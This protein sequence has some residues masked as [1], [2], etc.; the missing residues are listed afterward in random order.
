[1]SYRGRWRRIARYVVARQPF[2]SICGS[3]YRLTAD[4]IVPLA[5]G[6]TDE[7]ENL[8]VLCRT[9]NSKL[10]GAVRRRAPGPK[11]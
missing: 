7:W 4:H 8:R 10:G 5:H 1:M 2:C 3:R 11:S 9:C 6:G